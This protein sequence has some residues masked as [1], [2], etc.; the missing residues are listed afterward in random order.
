MAE[1]GKPFAAARMLM[2]DYDIVHQ[3]NFDDFLFPYIGK[4]PMVTTYHDVNFLTERNYNER[5]KRL[6][7][8]SLE[9]A[10]AIVAISENT[11]TDM[12]RHFPFVDPGKVRVIYH[13]I[14]TPVYSSGERIFPFP[15]ILFVGARHL[16]KNFPVLAKA[17]S[18]ISD[19]YPDLR[20]VCTQNPFT[21]DEHELLRRLGISE[22]VIQLGADESTLNR[23]YRDA[24]CFVFPSKYEG[25]GMPI[26]EAMVNRCPCILS[27]SSCF[28]EIAREAA[29]YFNAKS[30]DDLA[31]CILHLLSDSGLRSNLVSLG[32]NRSGD[33]S[34]DKC[35][36]EHLDLY[37]SLL[38]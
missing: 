37:K 38:K 7:T 3:T 21:P 9:R 19:R 24:E 13:G 34:W 26:L 25:F 2:R 33:F 27:R 36:E 29:L 17:F 6:Q 30:A 35:T 28:P 11:K 5:M 4:K 14:D 1:L 16:Y 10:D 12:L 23:L 31:D 15:Y 20:L 22:K 18:I 8:R 32:I